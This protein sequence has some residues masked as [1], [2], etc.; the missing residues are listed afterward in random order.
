MLGN[1]PLSRAIVVVL[2]QLGLSG[3]MTGQNRDLICRLALL[4]HATSHVPV[5]RHPP[6]PAD[7][8]LMD[9]GFGAISTQL[10]LK[11]SYKHNPALSFMDAR[12]VR[13]T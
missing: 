5:L 6:W 8:E 1:T 9:R 4:G 11:S 7:V 10:L 2:V 13:Y 12:T 3:D